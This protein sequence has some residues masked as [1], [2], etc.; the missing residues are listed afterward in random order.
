[1]KY[2]Y[3]TLMHYG[4]LGMKWGVRRYQNPDGTLTEAGKRHYAREQYKSQ[5]LA[6]KAKQAAS[7]K[8]YKEAKSAD[9]KLRRQEKLDRY[10]AKQE[11]K[12]L[13]SQKQKADVEKQKADEAQ[14]QASVQL[15]MH[16]EQEKAQWEKIEA[17]KIEAKRLVEQRKRELEMERAK[18]KQAKREAKAIS[19]RRGILSDQELKARIDRLKMQKELRELTEEEVAPGKKETRSVLKEVGGKTITNVLTGVGAYTAYRIFGGDPGEMNLAKTVATGKASFQ[20]E[21]KPED[22]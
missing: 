9:K 12:M 4:I 1:M 20:K 16:K 22:D 3:G 15:D 5:L 18:V 19:K 13:E 14:R 2:A 7:E 8:Q 17:D 10:R 6:E 21:K 11:R